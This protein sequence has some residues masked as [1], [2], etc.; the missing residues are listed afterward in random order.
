MNGKKPIYASK[1]NWSGVIIIAI[2]ILQQVQAF[3]EAGDYSREGIAA[4][5]M[6]VLIIIFRTFFTDK[7]IEL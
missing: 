5:V 7:E 4:M 2:G 1:I 6:G 3:Y